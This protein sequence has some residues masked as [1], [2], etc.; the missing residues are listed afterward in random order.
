MRVATPSDGDIS[1]HSTARVETP[2][3]IFQYLTKN[4]MSKHSTA[5]V[6]TLYHKLVKLAFSD[7]NPLHREGGDGILFGTLGF[8][9]DFNPLHR[10]GGDPLLSRQVC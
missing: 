1:I 9:H 2:P 4:F 3:Q 6:E 7:F 10:E 5:R 8:R